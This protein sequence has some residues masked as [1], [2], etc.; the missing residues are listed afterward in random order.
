MKVGLLPFYTSL[1]SKKLLE[2]L[3]PFCEEVAKMIK[4]FIKINKVA[5]YLQI[6]YL[7]WLIFATY[8]NLGVY[9]LN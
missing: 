4:D 5:G 9:I 3:E 7:L 8:L 2:R 1:Y 6:P